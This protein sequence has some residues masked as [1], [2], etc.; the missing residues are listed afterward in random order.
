MSGL[1]GYTGK[2]S[3][4]VPPP[5]NSGNEFINQLIGN[6]NDIN[7]TATIFGFLQDLYE[8]KH[9]RQLVYPYLAAGILITS[10]TDA[11]T[12][13]NFIEIVP[14][15]TFTQGF[16][17]HHLHLIAPSA[18][19]DYALGLY[20]GTT[21]IGQVTFSR[22]DKKDDVEGLTIF[23]IPCDANSQIQARLASSNAAQQDTVRLK[24]WY[25]PHLHS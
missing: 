10:H 19:G 8:E 4:R 20:Q 11:Y 2:A 6:R 25:H 18:N 15:N 5:N 13:G 7:N 23:A 16:H 22:T 21:P 24:I 17:I 1:G 9:A 12:L 3:L 14:A